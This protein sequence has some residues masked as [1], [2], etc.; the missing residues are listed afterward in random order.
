MP[1]RRLIRPLLFSL[2]PEWVHHASLTALTATPLASVLAPWTERK[3]PILEKK[4]FGLTFPNP[5]GLAAGFDKNAEGVAV[6]PKLGFGFMELGTI[7]PRP[8]PGNRRPRLFRLPAEGGLINR[9]GGWR[10]SNRPV[11]GPARRSGSISAKTRR[12]PWPR[13]AAI[14]FPAFAV[15]ASSAITSW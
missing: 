8:Q 2:P 6:W 10:K 9:L 3:Y 12:R 15:C 4:V 1:Y 13:R 11:T 7:T 14:M 5:I